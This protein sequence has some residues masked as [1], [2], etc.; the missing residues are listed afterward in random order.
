MNRTMVTM[1]NPLA[2]SCIV[3]YVTAYNTVEVHDSIFNNLF[4]TSFPM[5]MPAT[6]NIL[7][8]YNISVNHVSA[9]AGGLILALSDLNQISFSDCVFHDLTCNQ[10]GNVIYMLGSKNKFVMNRSTITTTL[11]YDIGS[12]F[13]LQNN[14]N[15]YPKL[16]FFEFEVSNIRRIFRMCD[17]Q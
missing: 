5:V 10:K 12:V 11:S 13:F 9:A 6:M 1:G 2:P 14:Q 16:N 4:T 17:D 3:F 15:I 8:F 7:T